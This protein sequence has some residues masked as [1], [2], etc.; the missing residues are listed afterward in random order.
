MNVDAITNWDGMF[1]GTDLF[2]RI[3]PYSGG[4][5]LAL[6]ISGGTGV[7]AFLSTG[8]PVTAANPANFVLRIT[9]ATGLPVELLEASVE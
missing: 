4:P 2:V 5:S 8:A 3:T 7:H 1:T 6:D 9:G